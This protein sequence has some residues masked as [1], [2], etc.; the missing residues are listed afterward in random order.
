MPRDLRD[1]LDYV[2]AEKALSANTRAA[3]QRDLLQFLAFARR[4]GLEPRRATQ[5]NLRDFLASLRKAELA[6]RS[7]ARKVS[8]LKQFYLF[9]LRED[10]VD[11]S[12]AELLTV[13]VK[14]KRLPK[15]LTI[16]EIFALI[17]AARGD[18]EAEIRD[19]AMLEVWYATGARV[20]EI[21][22]LEAGAIDWEGQVVRIRGKGGRERL[23]PL[24]AEAL[25]WAKRY[26]E[27]RHQQLLRYDLKET[28]IF[29]LSS[30]GR[31]FSRQAI[32]KIVKKYARQAGITR[33]IWPHMIRHTFATHVLQ[34]G[35][36]L[37]AVQELLGHRSITATEVYTHLDVENLK[38]M[39]SKYHPRG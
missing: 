14:Q 30:R 13:L 15:H 36:D 37:R 22:T 9:L 4:T 20:A 3:Y 2:A 26:Q 8:S 1:F 7:L 28:S 23:V 12:P 18:T 33:N 21:A 39:Q 29:F 24:H 31:G 16:Q 11:T 35:A 38:V 32:W 17:Q 34:G 27:L 25:T 5:K 19:R 6:P 10:R